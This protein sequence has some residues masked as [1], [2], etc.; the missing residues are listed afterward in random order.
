MTSPAAHPLT[1][2]TERTE[3][4][5][6]LTL[7]VL[8]KK[9][10]LRPT[11]ERDALAIS[12]S[13]SVSDVVG[14]AIAA[15]GISLDDAPSFLE[16]R[17]KDLL[18][19]PYILKD[20]E[21]GAVRVADAIENGENIAVFAD[22]DVDGATSSSIVRRYL[23]ETGTKT[24]L[25]IPDR[26]KE[27]YGP[28]AAAMQKLASDGANALVMLDCGT[29]AFDALDAAMAEGIDV[30]ILDHHVAEPRLPAAHAVI[31]PNRL[32]EETGL[33]DLCSAGLAFLFVV[34][35]NRVLRERGFWTSQRPEPSLTQFLD[36]VALGTVCDVVKLRGL[37]RAFVVQGLKVMGQ[38]R[39]I[40][41][42]ALSDVAGLNSAPEAYHL[43]FI[44]GPRINA[45]GRIGKSD[46]GAILLST[47][48][49]G[50][51]AGIATKLDAL[52]A[53]RKDIEELMTHDAMTQAEA[54][55]K[56][57]VLTLVAGE[58]WHPGVVGIVASRLVERFNRPALV[59]AI[60]GED[61]SGSGRSIPGIDLGTAIIA[62]RQSGILSKGGGHAMA[63][64]FS[65]AKTRIEEFR[66]FLNVRLARQM[67]QGDIG[68]PY[69]L[70]GVLSSSGVNLSLAEDLAKL[71]PFGPGNAEPRFAIS[72]VRVAY[73]DPVGKDHLRLS[74]QGPSGTGRLDAIAFRCVG[75]PLGD[76]LQ[77]SHSHPIWVAGKIKADTWQGRTKVKL[78]IE[79]A[80]T[81]WV[82]T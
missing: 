34:A 21:N 12:Q 57:A 60:D 35:V 51:A 65:L 61:A 68:A 81:A 66:E 2:L 48:D 5:D 50:E 8:G 27:G 42:C 11:P 7:S 74:L 52:N 31:N 54:Q 55:D 73:C 69:N 15:R 32:D 18:P 76:I 16:P 47:S 49:Y 41:L 13:L 72:D 40:G 80:A 30:V 19:D 75:T 36:L 44:L 63:A 71:A 59:V 37:N 1:D 23:A 70:D 67:E 10:R 46:L 4:G 14:R 78:H 53:E 45:G 9:W 39:N 29:T 22:Y 82:P 79:D 64:G 25:Y 26:L 62:A 6:T 38:R 43:G 24:Q 77:R 33:E 17:L 58:G 28:S 56:D 3:D 20:M